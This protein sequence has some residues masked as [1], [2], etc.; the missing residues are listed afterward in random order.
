MIT[1]FFGVLGHG[2]TYFVIDPFGSTIIII[3]VLIRL[4]AVGCS[5]TSSALIAE[6]SPEAVRGS[7]IRFFS[8]CGAV[9]IMVAGIAVGW[10]FDNWHATGPFVLFA[11][12]AL[13]VTIWGLLLYR[14]EVA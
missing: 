12:L 1:L 13:L 9:G 10:L 11:G 8:M 14:S 6:R 7:V 3:A 4:A 2:S 5:I